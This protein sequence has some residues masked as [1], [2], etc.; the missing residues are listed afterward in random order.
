MKRMMIAMML[1][2]GL[3]AVTM[4]AQQGKIAERKENQ[5]KRIANGVK[6]G[7]LTAGETAHLET[8]EAKLNKEV[9]TDRKDNGGNLTNN[10][11]KQINQQQNTLSKDIYRDKHNSAVQ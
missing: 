11:K 1:M 4:P 8:R 3:L 10:E 5:Q 9:R 2:G 6:S 7:Q